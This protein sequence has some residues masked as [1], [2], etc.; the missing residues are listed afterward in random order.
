M[1]DGDGKAAWGRRKVLEAMLEELERKM[2]AQRMAR[3]EGGKG[4]WKGVGREARAEAARKA[5]RARWNR[6]KAK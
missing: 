4:R 3:A 2:A 1:S 5:A 6:R